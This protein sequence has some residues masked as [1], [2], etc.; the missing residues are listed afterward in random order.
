[1][2]ANHMSWRIFKF[3]WDFTWF[4]LETIMWLNKFLSI[5]DTLFWL[6]VITLIKISQDFTLIN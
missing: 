2:H 1:M 3:N 6:K 4:Y 5:I